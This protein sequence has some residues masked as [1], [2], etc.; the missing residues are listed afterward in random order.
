MTKKKVTTKPKVS[1][2][3]KES[4]YET[5]LAQADSLIVKAWSFLKKH[6]GKLLVFILIYCGY[7]FCKLVWDDVKLEE[8]QKI[9]S[10]G[11]STD[12]IPPNT[13][14]LNNDT[15]STDTLK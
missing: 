1:E 8:Q 2:K 7:Q 15:T 12:V 10:I 4:E 5:K 13:Y 11:S 6:W 3:P 9:K 14:Q